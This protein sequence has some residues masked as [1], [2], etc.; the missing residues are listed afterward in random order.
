MRT[1]MQSWPSKCGLARFSLS[2]SIFRGGLVRRLFFFL[3]TREHEFQLGVSITMEV[4]KALLS[5]E[6]KE[7]KFSGVLLGE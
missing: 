7:S 4:V 5:I 6:D 1:G 2:I 3:R